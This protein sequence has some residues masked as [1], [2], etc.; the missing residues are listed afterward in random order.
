MTPTSPMPE[1]GEF[2]ARSSYSGRWYHFV[3]SEGLLWTK[4]ELDLWLPVPTEHHRLV[5]VEALEELCEA[6]KRPVVYVL[7]GS[8]IR[9]ERSPRFA[10]ARANVGLR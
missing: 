8:S 3:V 7:E 1:E 6:A 5:T 2:L 10:D 4:G 9:V